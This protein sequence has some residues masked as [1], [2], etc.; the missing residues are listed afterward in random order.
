MARRFCPKCGAAREFP[1]QKFYTSCGAP[2]PDLAPAFTPG[3]REAGPAAG[4]GMPGRVVVIAGI[5][6]PGAAA[7]LLLPHLAQV[8]STPS[9]GPPT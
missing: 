7:V 4:S 3:A 6:V 9:S 8:T 2:L 1:V 5:L